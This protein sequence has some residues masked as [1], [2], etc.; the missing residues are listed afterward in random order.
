MMPPGK[1]SVHSVACNREHVFS[2][3]IW[4]VAG[5]ALL[6][7]AGLARALQLIRGVAEPD[8]AQ[9][10][11]SAAGCRSLS[12]PE[13]ARLPDVLPSL[14]WGA[15]QHPCGNGRGARKHIQ[16]HKLV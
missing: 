5:E 1:P 2:S 8:G 7:P 11:G 16:L 13:P 9:L 10:G 3:C 14:D 4:E 12:Y 6:S 15:S